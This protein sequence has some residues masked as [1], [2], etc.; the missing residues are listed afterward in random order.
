[1]VRLV[2]GI[3]L[4]AAHLSAQE[5]EVRPAPAIVFPADADSNSPA[6]WNQGELVL[7]TST[8]NGPVRSAGR[9]YSRLRNPQPV[10]LG[11]SVNVPYWIESVWRDTDGTVLAWYH[12]EP[13]GLCPGTNLTSPKI[14]ALVSRDEGRSFIDLG[15]VLESG[16]RLACTARNGYFA[17]GH[18]DFSVIVDPGR[19][20]FYFLFTNYSGPLESQGVAVARLP[21]HRRYNPFGAVEK[22]FEG[23]WGEPGIGGRVT[24]IFPASRNWQRSSAD[25]F[26]GPSVHWNYYLG[27]YVMLLN[28][29]CCSPG[30]PQEGIYISYNDSLSNPKGWSTP[31]KILGS[32]SWWYPQVLGS[33]PNGTDRLAGQTARLFIYGIS[34]WDLV[35][36]KA[37][38]SAGNPAD[39]SDS[40]LPNYRLEAQKPTRF[41]RK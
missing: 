10:V 31:V 32:D 1:M 39:T 34:E 16:Y 30:W 33:R 40:A 35:F 21:F 5:V 20:Y 26:W 6:F 9:D 17:G 37:G 23:G 38:E 12:H 8:G 29:S 18:G 28:R 22:Y 11:H 2:I 14:G 36:K 25:S 13:S 24:A 4:L 19:T 15:I 27:K 3:G 41:R 7:F